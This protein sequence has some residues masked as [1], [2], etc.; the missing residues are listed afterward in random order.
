MFGKGIWVCMAQRGTYHLPYTFF[1]NFL[2]NF[3]D[4]SFFWVL[5][6]FFDIIYRIN[7]ETKREGNKSSGVIYIL[8]SIYSSTIF[9][10]KFLLTWVLNVTVICC[11]VTPYVFSEMLFA[12]SKC[13]NHI[14]KVINLDL[15]FNRSHLWG[16]PGRVARSWLSVVRTWDW[17]SARFRTTWRWPKWIAPPYVRATSLLNSESHFILMTEYWT[18]AAPCNKQHIL[19]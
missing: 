5:Q 10:S 19:T 1:F 18:L 17:I 7:T 11:P 14:S 6:F 2:V 16:V 12:M 13:Q 15:N 8:Y 3:A 4:I 9:T